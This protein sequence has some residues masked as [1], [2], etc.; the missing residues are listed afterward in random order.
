MSTA[1]V[2]IQSISAQQKDV[3]TRR[4]PPGSPAMRTHGSGL[5]PNEAKTVSEVVGNKGHTSNGLIFSDYVRA[6]K[7]AWTGD[8]GDADL[9]EL[10]Y[11]LIANPLNLK[12][13]T[14]E[15][16]RCQKKD[17]SGIMNRKREAHGKIREHCRDAAIESTIV[18][19]FE[20]AVLP[21]LNESKFDILR[22]TL[23]D[24][25]L[26]S[27]CSQSTKEGLVALAGEENPAPFLARSFQVSLSWENKIPTST[28]PG[29]AK[30]VDP[31]FPKFKGK[32]QPDVPEDI[33]EYEL[34]Y[35]DA[36]VR[37]YSEEERTTFSST[38]DIERYPRH[39]S[40]LL[41]QRRDYYSAEFIR[42]CMRD[43]YDA[44]GIDQFDALEDEVF[45][46][47]IDVHERSF[48]TGKDRLN[49]V[50]AHAASLP[51]D[52]IWVNHE[53]DWIRNNVKKG[54]CHFLVNDRR[55][56]GWLD[57]DR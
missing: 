19:S 37:V 34:P 56:R 42:R 49:E 28:R 38:A 11:G 4:L 13:Q 52:G 35:V 32:I 18:D 15:P 54:V 26:E 10:L 45:D 43:V 23:T 40:H 53:T 29:A 46:G 9:I 44:D 14:G 25:I 50:L 24:L 20:K 2:A 51:M 5:R 12:G 47:I 33:A 27:E 30:D 39:K 1:P 8:I 3:V 31:P 55:I 22:R 41:R 48:P 7:D 6:L 16:I 21:R 36:L 17:A 57:E